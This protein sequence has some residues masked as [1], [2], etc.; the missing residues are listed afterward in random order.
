VN[1]RPAIG[2]EV[3]PTS[4]GHT[5]RPATAADLPA[6]AR[7][8]RE[9]TNA[10]LR[11]LNLAEIPDDLGPILRLYAHLQSTDPSTFVVAEQTNG[12][13]GQTIDAFVVVAVRDQLRYLSMLYVVPRAQG[14]GLGRALLASVLSTGQTMKAGEAGETGRTP[15]VCHATSTDSA[16]PISNGL[17]ASFGMVPRIPLLHLVGLPHRPD[18]LPGLPDTIGV[19]AFDEI[20]GSGSGLRSAALA[21]EIAAL[22]RDAL[23][24]EHAVDHAFVVAEGRRGFLYHD[25]T[26]VAVGYGYTS[27]S[28]RVGPIAVADPALLGAV[29]GHLVTAVRPRGAFGLWVPG[30][31][32]EL[33]VPL[34]R[35]GFRFDGFP[36][37]LCW[38]RPFADFSRYLPISPGL[39]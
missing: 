38:D 15:A 10:Y 4:T 1:T 39:L 22:D 19:S 12:G 31:A 25:R 21:A 24:V 17:Y 7:I 28:G 20:E 33:V 32:G 6:C 35:A 13:P 3:V 8:W 29:V 2:I 37:L 5:L 30:S 14:R 16:Q 34:L 36:V 26:G 18:A 11:P 9:S 23:G 27:E